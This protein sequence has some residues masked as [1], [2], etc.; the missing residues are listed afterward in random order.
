[1]LARGYR[2]LARP[3][4]AAAA[5]RLP[6]PNERP[7][8]ACLL[9]Q[10]QFISRLTAVNFAVRFVP[11]CGESPARRLGN[12]ENLRQMVTSCD[13]TEHMQRNIAARTRFSSRARAAKFG[14]VLGADEQSEM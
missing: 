6:S 10:H 7:R 8:Y 9:D 4:N 11:R 1:M 5:A 2:F 3:I 13:L 14:S 12:W